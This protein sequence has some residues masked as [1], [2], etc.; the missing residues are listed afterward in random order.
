MAISA[1]WGAGACV[2][3]LVKCRPDTLLT[4]E[5]ALFCPNQKARWLAITALDMLTEILGWLL[6]VKLC[7]A[8]N[9][10]F[11]RKCQVVL[12]FTFRL[13]LIALSAFHLSYFDK[14]LE[15]DEPQFAVNSSLLFQQTMIL[16]SLISATVPNLKNFM[17]SFS[18]GMGLPVAFDIS[19]Y[20]SSNLYAMRPLKSKSQATSSAVGGI[21]ATSSGL[22]R[23]DVDTEHRARPQA[24]RP[25]QL[26]QRTT[27][28]NHTD[29]RPD[30]EERSSRNGSQELI[31]NKEVVWRVEYDTQRA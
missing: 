25:D 8:V 22:M 12:A 17:K 29:G 1:L 30:E 3:L 4:L 24:W 23:D 9:M 21:T 7:W 2:T 28:I 16:W 11:E 19:G 15:S 18:I 13:P 26:A 14:Y 31:I 27:V 5:N 20:G 10:S 6:V